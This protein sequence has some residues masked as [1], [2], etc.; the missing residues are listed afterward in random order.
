M[1]PILRPVINWA[2]PNCACRET[3]YKPLLPGMGMAQI[4]S[5]PGLGGVMAPLV[6]EGVRCKVEAVERQDYTNGDLVQCDEKG[7]AI[8]SVITTRDDG[9]D[10]TVL[11][12]TAVLRLC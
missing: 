4:H 9:Q 3:T 10:C 12:P 2:C 5:C 11:A 7:R 1:V 6:P 8:M